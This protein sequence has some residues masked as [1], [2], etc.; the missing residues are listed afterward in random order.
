MSIELL[1]LIVLFV[2][3]SGGFVFHILTGVVV[4]VAVLIL[5]GIAL[6]YFGRGNQV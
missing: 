3:L 4:F 1:L 5:A 6:R 2:W